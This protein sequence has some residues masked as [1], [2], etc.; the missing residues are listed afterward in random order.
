MRTSFGGWS[1][2]SRAF[3]SCGVAG[4]PGRRKRCGVNAGSSWAPTPTSLWKIL[5]CVGNLTKFKVFAVPFRSRAEPAERSIFGVVG[6]IRC[7]NFA[8]GKGEQVRFKA[9]DS[10]N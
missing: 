7:R 6:G 5:A 2:C 1:I 10:P 3:V 8:V 9:L 4:L